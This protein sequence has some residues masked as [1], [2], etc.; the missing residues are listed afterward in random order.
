MN[1]HNKRF[2]RA[3][4]RLYRRLLK[5]PSD[6]HLTDREVLCRVQLPCPEV[7]LRQARL[8]YFATLIHAQLPD[9]WAILS[10]DVQWCHLLEEDMDWMWHQLRAASDLQHPSERYEQWLFT[11]QHSPGYWKRLIR[12]AASHSVLQRLKLW[13]V[14]QFHARVL[15]RLRT[16][17]PCL[18]VETDIGASDSSRSYGCMSCQRSFKNAAGEAAHQFKVHSIPAASRSLFDQPVCGACLKHFHTMQKMKAH[19]YYSAQCRQV[20]QSRNLIC[21]MGPGSG[22]QEDRILDKIHDGLLPPLQCE[23][24]RLGALPTSRRSRH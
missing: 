19:L 2:H 14:E 23:G 12:R 17:T 20:L 8:R 9:L 7:L 13:R 15:P 21:P 6:Q 18:P 3:V 22:S 10:K 16:L 5:I 1:A 24:P 4:L 11:V